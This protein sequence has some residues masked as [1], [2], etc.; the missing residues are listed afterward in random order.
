MSACDLNSRSFVGTT[1][2]VFCSLALCASACAQSSP[3]PQPV[4]LPP[5]IPAPLDMSYPGT[6]ALT[7]D[8]T[9]VSDRIVAIHET[10]PVKAGKLILLYPEWLPGWHAPTNAI[11]NVAGLVVKANGK[12]VPWFRDRV[13][14]RAFHIDVP[15]GT[16]TLDVDFQFL[17]SINSQEGRISSKIAD[18]PWIFYVLY[19]AGHF[20][21]QIHF[22]PSV[23]LPDGWKFATALEVKS[24]DGNLIRFKEATLNTLVDSP[25]YAGI[26]FKRV[27]LSAGP[28][29]P[30]YLDLFADTPAQLE[31]TPE[32]L[33]YH[34]NMV[35]EAQ[36]LFHSRHY[37][38]YD[39]LVSVSD[40]MGSNGLEHHQSSEDGTH[41]NY[42][43]D[44]SAGVGGR[45]LLPHEYVHS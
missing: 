10:V 16:V 43:T 27:D 39:F 32:E 4:L 44:W 42:F 7:V 28:D 20:S 30:V 45:D 6:I 1:L 14:V 8:A 25:V 9:N 34:Q 29:N 12:K 35:K 37:D 11:A 15:Q 19:P 17:A 31:I 36:K 33:Q 22:A 23:R 5:P 13:T 40:S 26:N 21:R 41:A 3:G 38:H 2:A 18:L 24:Q